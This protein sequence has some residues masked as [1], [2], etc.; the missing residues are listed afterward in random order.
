[1]PSQPAP[2]KRHAD[3]VAAALAE[4]TGG[5]LDSGGQAILRMA[6]AFAVEL[7]ELLDIVEGDRDLT[8]TLVLGISLFHATEME[9]CV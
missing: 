1:M 9:H 2:G 4:R 3:A 6:R 7:A 8:V 5:R